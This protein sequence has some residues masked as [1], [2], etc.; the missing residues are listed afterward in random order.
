MWGN[1]C[2]GQDYTCGNP[3]QCQSGVLCCDGIVFFRDVGNIDV[4]HRYDNGGGAQAP[5]SLSNAR[6]AGGGRSDRRVT[7]AMIKDEGL[8]TA[9]SPAFIQVC[10]VRFCQLTL[11]G[12]AEEHNV[13]ALK[14]LCL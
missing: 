12:S 13:S 5:E 7:L 3:C 14:I 6:G 1:P 9:G 4:W 11:K 10:A 8:G 2:A